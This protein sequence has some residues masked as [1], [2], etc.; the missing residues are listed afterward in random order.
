M[1][2]IDDKLLADIGYNTET[3]SEEEKEQHKVSINKEVNR[4]VAERIAPELTNEQTVEFEDV[5]N[6]PDRTKRWLAE[7]HGDFIDRQDYQQ[8]RSL[9]DSDEEAMSFYAS[10]LWLRYAVPSY[11][12]IMQQVFDEYI[13]EL[14][15]M[16]A[17]VN[18]GLGIA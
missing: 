12:D 9:C 2:N 3:L 7:F 11:G 14:V 1:F 15:S 13:E 8:V 5:T 18:K 6:N 17:M 10:A 4:R 16:R